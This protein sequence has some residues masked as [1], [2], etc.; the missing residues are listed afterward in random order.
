MNL[1]RPS[2]QQDLMMTMMTMMTTM[3]TPSTL[4]KTTRSW[5]KPLSPPELMRTRRTMTTTI[6][7]KITKNWNKISRTISLKLLMLTFDCFRFSMADED[8]EDYDDY[9]SDEDY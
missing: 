5:S 7:T 6:Q 2:S 8:K 3:T 9:Y 4:T 1:S